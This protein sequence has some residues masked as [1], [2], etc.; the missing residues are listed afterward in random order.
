[1]PNRP[2]THTLLPVAGL[3]ATLL[4]SACS[5]VDKPAAPPPEPEFVVHENLSAAER[6]DAKALARMTAHV[7]PEGQLVYLHM[8][9]CCDQFNKAY[10]ADGRYLCAPS[11]GFTGQGDGRCPAWVHRLRLRPPDTAASNPWRVRD[12]L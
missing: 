8:A 1:M 11:G 5:S 7:E 10:D 4:V 3:A 9:L 6:V 12:T 2:S